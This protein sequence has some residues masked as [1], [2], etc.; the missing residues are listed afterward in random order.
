MHLSALSFSSTHLDDGSS[1]EATSTIVAIDRDKT[2]QQAV[3][4]TVDHLLVKM[5]TLVLVH[6]RTHNNSLMNNGYD[7]PE[8][9]PEDVDAELAQL[10]LPYRGFCARKGMHLKEVVL[11]DVNISRAIVEYITANQIQNIVLGASSR[12]ALTRKFRNADVPTCLM[13]AAPEYC[14][15]YV[16]YKGKAVSIR[17]AKGPA[18]INIAPPRQ[19]MVLDSPR[20]LPDHID[21]VIRSPFARGSSRGPP[22][23]LLSDRPLEQHPGLMKTPSRDRPLSSARTAPQSAFLEC[24]D[25]LH[26]PRSSFSRDSSSDDMDL[27]K[28]IEFQSIDFGNSVEFSSASHDSPTSTFSQ[29]DVEAEMKR[30]R[31]ELK[32]TMEMY[33]A[34]CKEAIMAK[35]KAKELHHLKMEE[36]RKFE[37]L[38]Q[39]EEAALAL[40][41]MEK[42]KCKAAIEHAEAAQR[43][44][45][46]EAQKRLKAELKAK[47]EAEEKRKALDTL[48]NSDVRYRKY[49]IEEIEIA[50]NRFSDS[51]KIGE[52]G[53]GP[54]FK[55]SLD[56]TPVAIKVLRPD[57]SQGRRQFQ[58]EVEVL[59]CIRHPNMVLLLGACS[60]YGCLVYEYMENGSLED[61]LFQRNNTPPIPWTVRFKIAAE[62]A[63]GLL[64][65][66]QTKPEPLVHRDLKPA[67]ILLDRN[68]VSKISDVGLARLV[69]PSVADSVTQYRMTS[70]AGTFCYIDP[71]YQQ[72]GML[73]TKSDI[74]S[75]GIMLLQIIT[76][77]PPMGLTHHVDKAIE[78]GMFAQMLD[79][80]ITDWPVEE[81]LA[82]AKLALKCAEL[83]R[84]DRPDLGMVIL[85]ELNH[86]RNIAHAYETI[87]YG[88]KSSSSSYRAGPYSFSHSRR[89]L[90]TSSKPSNATAAWIS[91][92]ADG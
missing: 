37:E 29:R 92:A 51:L 16:I 53:Y 25:S 24:L 49:T 31:L 81:A 33:N 13:K 91:S 67:N 84:K 5:P 40:V 76:A 57:A 11:E 58:Q 2:S 90:A 7:S 15:V 50:T 80:S 55:A 86:L 46:L 44:A 77:R 9:S 8:R 34:A 66:H 19:S 18:P 12:N 85:P 39:A 32:Q 23:S 89:S 36:A 71:E 64:F 6:V 68:Y 28:S 3:R 72:T 65:L 56:H 22:P 88:S 79:P 14:T 47:L 74:Y 63:T 42:S 4:W 61:R 30:L 43:I 69:P 27:P 70:T 1:V 38:R 52:G 41:E 48:A 87:R 82:F 78:K 45:E 10:F 60:E 54:V 35:Q 59:S 75:L 17:S 26:P 83:R 73:G 20:Q 62:I 21:D